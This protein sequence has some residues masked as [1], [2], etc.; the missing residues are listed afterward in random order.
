VLRSA[1]LALD[2]GNPF[3]SPAQKAWLVT[4]MAEGLGSA[5][6]T[7]RAA[8]RVNGSGFGGGGAL[9]M[10]GDASVAALAREAAAA[11]EVAEQ[12]SRM[13]ALSVIPGARQ[14]LL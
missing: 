1:A 3:W 14:R 4:A 7:G 11:A 6:G 8:G 2:H 5:I 13:E 9:A 10:D 12:R